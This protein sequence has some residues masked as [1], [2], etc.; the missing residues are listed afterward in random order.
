MTYK[1]ESFT[2][3]DTLFSDFHKFLF[4]VTLLHISGSFECVNKSTPVKDKNKTNNIF[5]MR[6][7]FHEVNVTSFLQVP[8]YS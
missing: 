6:N 7:L 5:I 4:Y 8:G 3:T 1:C 2:L